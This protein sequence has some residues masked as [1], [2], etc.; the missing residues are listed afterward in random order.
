MYGFDKGLSSY[1]VC[2]VL[3]ATAPLRHVIFHLLNNKVTTDNKIPITESAKDFFSFPSKKQ[4]FNPPPIEIKT[5]KSTA[6]ILG[7]VLDAFPEMSIC[8]VTVSGSTI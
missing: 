5:G 3:N 6:I 8:T 4:Y 2:F 1:P 7:N